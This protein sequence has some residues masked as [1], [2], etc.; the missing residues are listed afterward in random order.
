MSQGA[1]NSCIQKTP[2]YSNANCLMASTHTG[3]HIP[4]AWPE[5]PSDNS[6]WASPRG[7][8]FEFTIRV[9]AIVTTQGRLCSA[10]SSQSHWSINPQS[11]SH[12]GFSSITV[13]KTYH[14]GTVFMLLDAVCI[15]NPQK[16]EQKCILCNLGGMV[17]SLHLCCNLPSGLWEPVHV[18]SLLAKWLF[19]CCPSFLYPES[20]TGPWGEWEAD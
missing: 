15:P 9:P 14:E 5:P 4:A 19:Q 13:Y 12:E 20:P 2:L 10:C 17:H 7:V 16:P 3:I 1:L 8:S 6:F 18:P 11:W